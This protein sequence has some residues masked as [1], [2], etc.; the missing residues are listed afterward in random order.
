MS[1]LTRTDLQ[2]GKS[3]EIFYDDWGTGKPVVLIPWWPMSHEMW[4]YQTESLIQSGARVITYDRRGFGRSSRPWHGYDYDTLTDDLKTLLDEL[5]LRDV[6]L[7]GFSMGGGEVVRYFSRYEGTRVSKVVLV[8]SVTPYLLKTED[9]PEG[10][11][12]SVFDDMITKMDDDRVAFLDSFSKHFF[13]INLISKPLSTPLLEYYKILASMSSPRATKVCVE[14]FSQTDF[15]DEMA[16]IHVPTLIIHGESDKT[17]PIETSGEQ[18]AKLIRNNRFIQYVD[19]P[20]G[21]FYT[22]KERLGNDLIEFIHERIA[23]MM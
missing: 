9:N 1:Y 15:R 2:T 8:A 6:T 13:G 12:K 7:V 21:L 14:A 16:S 20:H 23:V 10:V 11:D 22:E 5:D 18:S 19:A 4:E 17:V 3:I